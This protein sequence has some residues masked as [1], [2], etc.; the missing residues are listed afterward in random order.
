MPAARA[1]RKPYRTLEQGAFINVQRAADAL[2]RGVEE[3]LKPTGL[4][5]TQY[6]ILRILRG[7]GPDGLA[8]GEVAGRMMTRDPDITRLLD[9]LEAR[10]LV[11]R[12]RERRDR[13]VV[14]SRITE[15]GL[16]LLEGLD[17]PVAETHRRQ[18]GHLGERRLRSLILLLELARRRKG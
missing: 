6:N 18:L 9:R 10:R 5:F 17:H 7:A 3:A 2:S 8:C 13:R 12:S 1:P 16:S 14:K 4:S 11:S 15:Q